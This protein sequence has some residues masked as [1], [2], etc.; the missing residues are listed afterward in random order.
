M[1]MRMYASSQVKRK[2]F[3]RKSE[4]QAPVVRKLDS[5]THRINRYP[6]DKHYNN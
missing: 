4:L 3:Q 2:S 6:K 5:A 1:F